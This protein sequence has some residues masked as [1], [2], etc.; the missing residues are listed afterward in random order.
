MSQEI[1]DNF[2]QQYSA[3]VFHLAQQKGSRLKPT[4]R[5]ETQVG[6]SAFYDRIGSVTAQLKVGRHSST[7]QL[8]TPHSR[9]R[10]TLADYE[11]ADLVDDQDK[12]RMLHDPTSEYAIAAMWAL[13]RAM[14][15]VIVEA[16]GGTAYAG[17]A[18][19]STVSL[20]NANKLAAHTGSALSDLNLKTLR[21]AKRMLDQAEVDPSIKRYFVCSAKQI[22]ALLG[23][24]EVTSSDYNSV[25]ALVQG[26]VNTFMG[27]EFIRS[28]RLGAQSSA[29]SG[30]T[31][32]GAVGSG[33]SLVGARKCYAYAM[34]GALLSI[35]QDM[36]GKISER[37]DKSYAMQVYACMSIGATRME[38]AKVVE[39]LCTE[40]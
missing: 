38:E 3:N 19:A 34:D 7:P 17:E 40:S 15:D 30:S 29:L 8:D 23:Q 37:A 32:T 24:T 5:N 16:L 13:G 35:G 21:A 22:E 39:V 33:S 28:E 11:W 31:S 14:D 12:I 26:E 25:K 2:S 1:T 36:K 20:A 4:V 10:V 18:G 6:K 9:R 27:F